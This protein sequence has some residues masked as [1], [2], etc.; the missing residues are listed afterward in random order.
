M[1]VRCPDCHEMAEAI[2]VDNG[3]GYYEYWGAKCFDSRPEVV[4]NCCEAY[5]DIHPS[6]VVPETEYDG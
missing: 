1:L 3:I 2:V 5:L 4:S 6:E